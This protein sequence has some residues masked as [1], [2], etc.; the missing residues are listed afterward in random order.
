MKTKKEVKKEP[1]INLVNM[2]GKELPKEVK[3]AVNNIV[4]Q[5]KSGKLGNML[6]KVGVCP[7]HGVKHDAKPMS[8]QV[9]KRYIKDLKKLG[10]RKVHGFAFVCLGKQTKTGL[11]LEG[12][13]FVNDMS[14]AEIIMTIAQGL[15]VT[16]K[17]LL[18]IALEM[19]SV[20]QKVSVTD[21]K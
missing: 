15:G 9:E 6:G 14:N 13:N 3:D 20:S 4:E 1:K 8:K 5:I 12:G 19:G 17:G 11:M 2:A 21:N 7:V 16:G 10:T 18:N